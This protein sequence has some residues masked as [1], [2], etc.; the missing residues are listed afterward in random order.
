MAFSLTISR[1]AEG[2]GVGIET[3]RFYERRG[4][5]QQP[6]APRDGGYRVYDTAV[7]ERTRFIR[8]TPELG[9]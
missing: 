9:F 3:I 6:A 8:Q 1:A 2:A 4:L 7:V 5:I